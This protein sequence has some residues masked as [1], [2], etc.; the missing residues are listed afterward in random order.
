MLYR[1]WPP[2]TARLAWKPAVVNGFC[3]KTPPSVASVALAN[4]T[5][6]M[7]WAMMKDESDYIPEFAST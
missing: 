4:K 2:L 3:P 1:K 6:H 5:V 7:A